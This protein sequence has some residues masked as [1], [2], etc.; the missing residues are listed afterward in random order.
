M[1]EVPG[2]HNAAAEIQRKSSYLV[3]FS[4][5]STIGRVRP[6]IKVSSHG[7]LVAKNLKAEIPMGL[8]L[9][10][11]PEQSLFSLQGV[12]VTLVFVNDNK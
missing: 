7:V 1:S 6:I 8:L 4:D 12:G 5:R 11:G 3:L 10:H 2:L 9:F